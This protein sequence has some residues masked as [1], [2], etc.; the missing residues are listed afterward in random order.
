MP[1]ISDLAGAQAAIEARLITQWTT[2]RIAYANEDPEQ[3]WP[4]VDG[5]NSPVPWVFVELLGID[6]NIIGTGTPGNQVVVDEGLI[7][8]HVFV[9]VG[10]G[11]DVPRAHAV[12]LGEIFRQQKFYDDDPTAYVR[13]YTPKLDGGDGSSDDGEWFRTTCTV[14]F[15]FY[16]RA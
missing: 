8:L 14:P 5:N 11:R 10:W 12:A 4:P 7:K 2:T 15:E 3:P 16:H 9:P 6:S 13:S 1:S